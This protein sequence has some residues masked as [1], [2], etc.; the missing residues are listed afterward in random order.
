MI[1][2]YGHLAGGG[3]NATR[4]AKEIVVWTTL[5]TGQIT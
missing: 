1:N 2:A 4:A 5:P 3:N